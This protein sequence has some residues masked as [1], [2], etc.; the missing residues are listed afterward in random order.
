MALHRIAIA[1]YFHAG[2]MAGPDPAMS[3]FGSGAN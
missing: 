2:A 1:L 3:F